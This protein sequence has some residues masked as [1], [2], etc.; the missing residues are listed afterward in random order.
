MELLRSILPILMAIGTAMALD[1]FTEA[2][3]LLAPNFRFDRAAGFSSPTSARR[4]ALLRSLAL[5]LVAFVLWLGIFAPL[6]LIGGSQPAIP[7][8]PSI[9]DLFL[10]HGVFVFG[11]VVWYLLGFAGSGRD[12]A[13]AWIGQLGLRTREVGRELG[14]GLAAGILGW[15]GV[16]S[17]VLL[18]ALVA[19][20]LGGEGVLP[21]EAPE[22][23]G[24]IVGL[25]IAVRVALA[26][27][28][29]MVEELFFRG[30]LQ[31]RGGVVLS[32]ALF[33]LAHLS[34]EQPFLLVGVALLSLLFAFLVRW[35]QSIWAAVVAHA[36]FD[37][38]QLLIVIPRALELMP[39]G[40]G[41]AAGGV[42]ARLVGWLA[43]A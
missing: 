39:D 14:I 19:Y 20:W 37:A 43:G 22:I 32:S 10:L 36:V 40:G 29:G 4:A 12:L 42:A 38:I 34:Y 3:G 15:L 26:A 28:A 1:R 11:L 18:V 31:P 21:T 25:P 16:I 23:L 7:Q 30:F 35:R 13:T 27:S 5:G 33:V 41:G 2:K 8:H 9:P 24:W 17:I 6:G